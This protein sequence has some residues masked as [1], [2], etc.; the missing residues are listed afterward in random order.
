MLDENR[1]LAARDGM[2]ARLID[3]HLGCRVSAR[4]QL[5]ELLEACA[6]HAT[7][8]GC[9][10]ELDT[11]ERMLRRTGAERQV[12]LARGADRLP[13]LV[14]MMADAFCDAAWD[15]GGAPRRAGE[16]QPDDFVH[17]ARGG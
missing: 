4:E 2:D 10:A 11:V 5:T 6:P 17:L 3:P 15:A 13:G 12:A 8:L 1:F 16:S 7:Q 9:G 14:R